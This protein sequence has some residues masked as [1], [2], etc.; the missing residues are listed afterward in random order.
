MVNS[1]IL[2]ELQVYVH[3]LLQTTVVN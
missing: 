1:T 2:L 3:L